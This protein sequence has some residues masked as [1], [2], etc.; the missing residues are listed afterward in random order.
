MRCKCF[1][2][3]QQVPRT[4]FW[5]ENEAFHKTLREN[6]SVS[7]KKIIKKK[8]QKKSVYDFRYTIIFPVKSST[9]MKM[10]I[11]RI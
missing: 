3:K 8:R 5:W 11:S 9:K 4:H 10:I 6:I 1:A 7:Q 2:K